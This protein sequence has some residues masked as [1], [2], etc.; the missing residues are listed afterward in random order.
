MTELER[1]NLVTALYR[2]LYHMGMRVANLDRNASEITESEWSE[3]M[4]GIDAAGHALSNLCIA[5]AKERRAARKGLEQARN[6]RMR[7]WIE[8]DGKWYRPA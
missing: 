7:G 4:V 8:V 1:K 2:K 5:K 3:L 6:Y